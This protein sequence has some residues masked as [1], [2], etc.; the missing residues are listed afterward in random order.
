M[1]EENF[2]VY[3]EEEYR[4][5]EEEMLAALQH[6]YDSLGLQIH[7]KKICGEILLLLDDIHSILHDTLEC[8]YP[9]R[10]SPHLPK[11]HAPFYF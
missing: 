7:D 4:M 9:P 3:E 1:V 2:T 6:I 10:K 11:I 8:P 5:S